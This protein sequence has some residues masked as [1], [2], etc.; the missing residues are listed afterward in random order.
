MHYLVWYIL[1]AVREN[2]DEYLAWK[3]ERRKAHGSY[4]NWNEC[5]SGDT[6]GNISHSRI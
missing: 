3:A 2:H 5:G 4:S 6:G 1:Q